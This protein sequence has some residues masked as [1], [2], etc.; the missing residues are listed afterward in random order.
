MVDNVFQKFFFI[1]I[2]CIHWD[3]ARGFL[4]FYRF[5]QRLQ[6]S[7]NLDSNPIYAK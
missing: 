4:N 5:L 6:K 2:L 7:V 1:L 3:S